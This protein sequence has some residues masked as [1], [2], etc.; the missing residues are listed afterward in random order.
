[1]PPKTL[2]AEQ[3]A[4]QDRLQTLVDAK[5]L[6]RLKAELVPLRDGFAT[7]REAGITLRTLATEIVS[8]HPMVKGQPVAAITTLIEQILSSGAATP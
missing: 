7:A 2:N 5:K 8:I 1:M 4:V 3:K 6:D